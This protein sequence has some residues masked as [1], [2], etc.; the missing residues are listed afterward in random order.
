MARLLDQRPPS[1]LCAEVES[2]LSYLVV[3]CRSPEEPLGPIPRSPFTCDALSLVPKFPSRHSP[4][5]TLSEHV[6]PVEPRGPVSTAVR[7][8]SPSGYAC[9]PQGCRCRRVV[10][11]RGPR[12]RAASRPSVTFCDLRARDLIFYLSSAATIEPTTAESSSLATAKL[13]LPASFSDAP[14]R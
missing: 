6:G 4:A 3:P 14:T 13:F 10:S 7:S 9:R 5:V 1:V 8:A 2:S 12:G 11:W